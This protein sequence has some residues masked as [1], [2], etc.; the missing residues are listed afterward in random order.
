MEESSLSF[1]ESDEIFWNKYENIQKHFEEIFSYHQLSIKYFKEVLAEIEHHY[2]K[3]NA[4]NANAEILFKK[5]TKYT[6]IFQLFKKTINFYNDICL[7]FICNTINN[8]EAYNSK[9]KQ[10]TPAY[11]NFKQFSEMYKSQVKKFNKIKEKF[12]ES[13]SLAESKT[14]EKMQKKNEKQFDENNIISKK[15]KKDV[16]DNF[17]KY[18]SSIEEINKKRE[19]FVSKQKNLIQLDIELELFYK[20]SFY[21]IINNFLSLNKNKTIEFIN[22][23]FQNLQKQV[24]EKNIE[25]EIKDYFSSIKSNGQNDEKSPYVFEGYKTKLNY[26]NCSKSEEFD[27]SMETFDFLDKNFKEILDTDTFEKEKLKGNL[28]EWIKKFFSFDE[29][30]IEIDKETIEQYYYKA[31]KEPYTHKSF[32][33]IVTDMRTN[34][35]FNRNRQLV[36]LLGESLKIILE[37]ARKNKDYWT[38]KNCLILSQ[39]FYYLEDDKKIFSCECLKKNKWLETYDFWDEF[40]SYMIDE[41][42]KKL[43]MQNSELNLDDIKQNKQYSAKLN[44]KIG[45]VIFSQLIAVINN[46]LMFTDNNLFAVELIESLKEKYIYFPQKNIEVLYQTIST[47][48]NV[49]KKLVEESNKIAFK[50]K[51]NKKK[52]NDKKNLIEKMNNHKLEKLME[53]ESNKK[54]KKR[55]GKE[56]KNKKDDVK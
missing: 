7:K 46:I 36:D 27:A 9:L 49:I 55:F 29:K 15:I 47:D 21:D 13:V 8:F 44:S 32:L 25:K 28:R 30:S 51:L 43:I 54:D 26:D 34:T 39:T 17:K 23:R 4:I 24:E 18:Q 50:N 19:E 35:H 45:D 10:L 48:E 40:C 42:L 33:K 37:E 5:D 3:L 31:L 1:D 41:E 56:E 11:S 52:A 14:M 6:N 53:K 16:L 20:N 22:H 12:I 38:A 2:V